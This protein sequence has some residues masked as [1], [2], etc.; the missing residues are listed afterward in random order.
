MIRVEFR[1]SYPFTMKQFRKLFLKILLYFPK[2]AY[3]L[4]WKVSF[5]LFSTSTKT[6]DEK[7]VD[8]DPVNQFSLW[9]DEA[10][11]TH[12][13]LPNATVLATVDGDGKPSARF[14]LLKDFDQRGFVFYTN[15]ESRKSRELNTNDSAALTLYWQEVARQVRI[16][17]TVEKISAEESDR[18][19][20]TRPRD[21]QIG[22]WAS[23]QSDVIENR[24][25][26]DR[27]FEEFQERFS[28]KPIPRP[29]HWGGFRLKPVR[30][31]FWQ[32]RIA[33]L[34]DR[35][36]Y[37]RDPAGTWHAKRLAP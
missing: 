30:I 36:V 18:Y 35:V 3:D 24:G 12:P 37:E 32:G 1:H 25:E 23:N 13:A 34:H 11:L 31:E 20:A 29:P 5:L 22:A 15:Y 10:H 33:R 9:Y 7:T 26:L 28:G 21:S 16:E 6:L 2:L 8:P 19:F 4:V 14:V 27:K 17:G